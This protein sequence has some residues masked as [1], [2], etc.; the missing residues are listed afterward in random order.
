MFRLFIGLIALVTS[1]LLGQRLLQ[2]NNNITL[3]D[4]LPHRQQ[5]QRAAWNSGAWLIVYLAKGEEQQAAYEKILHPLEEKT[6]RGIALKVFAY[7]EVPDSLLRKYPIMLIGKELPAAIN[8]HL[9]LLPAVHFKSTSA[10]LDTLNL[11]QQEDLLQLT[12]LPGYWQDTLP[13]HLI[14]GKE[15]AVIQAH[16]TARLAQGIRSFLWSAWG[17]EVQRS[18]NIL[19][20]GYFNDSTWVMDKQI[21]FEFPVTPEDSWQIKSAQLQAYDGAPAPSPQWLK[22]LDSTQAA[23]EEFTGFTELESLQIKLY[24]SVERKALRTKSMQQA[25]LSE[26]GRVS[27]LVINDNFQGHEWGLHY[28]A[29]LREALGQAHHPF[30]EQGLA[31]QW[32]DDIR[33]ASWRSWVR[34]LADAAALP[35]FEL[36]FNEDE[37]QQLAPLIGQLAAAA[38]V[39]YRLAILGKADFLMEYRRGIALPSSE[40]YKSWLQWIAQTYPQRAIVDKPI[41]EHRLNGFTLAHEGYR[42]Y[43]G[44]GSARARQS[45]LLMKQTGIEAVAIVPYSFMADAQRPDPIPVSQNAGGE[46]DE[47]VLFAHLS[48]QSLGQF[49]LLKPQIWLGGGS[50][51][52]DVSFEREQDW[53][54]FFTNYGRWALHYALIAEMYGFDAYCIGTELRYTTLKKPAAWRKLTQSIR[55]IYH[56]PLT[57]AAN[58]GEECEQLTF[59]DI[60]DFIGINCYYPLDKSDKATDADLAKGAA[61]VVEKMEAISKQAGRPVW[62]TEIGYRSATAPW[63]EPHAEAG[64]RAIDNEAQARSYTA[65]LAACEGKDWLRGFFWWK[66]SSDLSHDESRGRGYTPYGK[67]AEDVLSRYYHLLRK[68]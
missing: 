45:L 55:K 58:W 43:N 28:R 25:S 30:Y 49:T 63:I 10:Q 36:L 53:Q 44:Y 60:F 8:A 37:R 32:V 64:D 33:G 11:D 18:G 3:S 5:L 46:N 59:W 31:L 20:Q 56:G 66:W 21:H 29:W 42:I 48:A 13:M 9:N 50:W 47:A 40:T 6:F 4:T 26:D 14:W 65:M 12:Y 68:K 22:T 19:Q 2:S 16:L 54:T 35:P 38:W 27:H 17:Y 67:P 41:P 1:L 23:I 51:P 39:D 24:P 15:D 57:Y 34:S 7:E 62:L 52:G 61:R